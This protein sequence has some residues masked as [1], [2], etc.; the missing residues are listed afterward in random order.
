MTHWIGLLI[1]MI[2]AP[3]VVVGQQTVQIRVTDRPATHRDDPIYL[4]GNFNGWDPVDPAMQLQRMEDGSLGIT[5]ILKDVPSDRLEYKFTRGD[6][7]SSEC[8]IEGRLTGPRLA[9]LAKDTT[10]VVQI[11]GWR[12]DFPSSTASPNVHVLDS[13][14][15]IPQLDRSRK[16]LIYLPTG[17]AD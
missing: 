6:W 2:I 9:E 16:I 4:T 5:V 15:Y 3:I 17:Y 10:I 7:Q 1:M 14:F 8:T 12:D 11:E 13:A